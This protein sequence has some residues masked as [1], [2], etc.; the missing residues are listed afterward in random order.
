M[1]WCRFLYD[2]APLSDMLVLSTPRTVAAVTHGMCI[3][4]T[5]KG[6]HNC[7]LKVPHSLLVNINSPTENEL[8]VASLWSPK[9]FCQYFQSLHFTIL[10]IAHGFYLC[11]VVNKHISTYVPV[12]I[13]WNTE[14]LH[15]LGATA[16]TARHTDA[17]TVHTHIHMSWSTL[18]LLTTSVSVCLIYA[19]SDTIWQN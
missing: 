2:L 1:P 14:P 16:F 7:C 15:Q 5:V 3:F 17:T 4:F 8:S 9:W 11:C 13:T 19:I 10:I 6:D 18:F 12:S